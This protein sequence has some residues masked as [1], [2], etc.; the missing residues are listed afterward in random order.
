MKTAIDS[1]IISTL[2]SN[3]PSAIRASE[4]LNQARGLGAVVISGPVYVELAGHPT[5]P[6]RFLDR[7]LKETG[8]AVEF[9]LDE[10]VWRRAAAGFANYAQRRRSSGGNSPKRLLADFLI[11]AHATICTDRLFTLDASRYQQDL[12]DL[13]LL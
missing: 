1:N 11:G 7:F 8:I 10:S 3:E 13:K 9:L 5:A 4:Q 2:W 6:L 12:P